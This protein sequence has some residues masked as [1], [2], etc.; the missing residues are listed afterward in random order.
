MR[1]I[2][3]I[4]AV[5][6]SSCN[7]SPA[8][9]IYNYQ[10]AIPKEAQN[11]MSFLFKTIK[12]QL[13]DVDNFDV[14]LIKFYSYNLPKELNDLRQ[15][16]KQLHQ[17]IKTFDKDHVFVDLECERTRKAA[18]LKA[19]KEPPRFYREC[20]FPYVYTPEQLKV[21]YQA[22]KIDNQIWN[23]EYGL[24]IHVEYG[25]GY[26]AY[27]IFTFLK[28]QNKWHLEDVQETWGHRYN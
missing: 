24:Q 1:I 7:I 13:K 11:E 5:I 9:K 6:I 25:K 15:R 18:D 4:F 3:I 10:G 19:G 2:L 20:N 28:N 17:L 16:S 12:K 14:K 21:S 26:F 27:I 8:T 23:Y 22:T